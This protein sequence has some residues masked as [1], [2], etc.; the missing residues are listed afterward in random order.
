MDI[1]TE[2]DVKYVVHLVLKYPMSFWELVKGKVISLPDKIY[3]ITITL[4]Q[5]IIDDIS[6]KLNIM[7]LHDNYKRYVKN[8]NPLWT[9]SR[10]CHINVEKYKYEYKSCL[11]ISFINY[12]HYFILYSKA[13]GYSGF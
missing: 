4:N 13:F 10:Q 2:F 6:G 1:K 8:P 3:A 7:W 12:S 5:P 11:N 9:V